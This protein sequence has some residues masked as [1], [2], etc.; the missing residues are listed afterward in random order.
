MGPE[1][2]L[3]TVRWVA[4]LPLP[5]FEQDYEFV[6]LR[7]EME[8]PF[9][10]GRVVSNKGVDIA[11]QEYDAHFAEEHVAHSNALHSQIE[12]RGPYFSGPLAR[13]NLNFDRLSPLAREARD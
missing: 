12:G 3:K 4:A 7:H 8:Y 5:E 11:V 1:A 10:E 6:S 13:Y 9:N 2:A